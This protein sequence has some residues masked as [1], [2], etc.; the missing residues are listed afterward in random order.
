[1]FPTRTDVKRSN[2]IITVRNSSFMGYSTNLLHKGDMFRFKTTM[3]DGS[4]IYQNAL[5]H[6][7]IKPLFKIDENDRIQWYILA[8]VIS[9]NMRFTYER[10]IAPED[11]VEVIPADRVNPYL[12]T[13]FENAEII[14]T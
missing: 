7:L 8:Q 13:Y 14:S 4:I 1:M 2:R 3:L 12:K 9:D 10:W 6:G 5:S 11:V